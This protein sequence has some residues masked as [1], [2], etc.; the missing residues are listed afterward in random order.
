MPDLKKH[1][2]KLDDETYRELDEFR[3]KHE[4]YSMAAFRLLRMYKQV[5]MMMRDIAGERSPDVSGRST[6][7]PGQH[8]AVEP[9]LKTPA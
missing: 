2:V 5:S 4:T 6:S 9:M 1:S 7:A 3:L 8:D